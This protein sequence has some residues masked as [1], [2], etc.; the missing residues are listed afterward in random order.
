MTLE[1]LTQRWV[2]YG[3]A[4]SD[5]ELL[6]LVEAERGMPAAEDDALMVD[7][8]L[9]SIRQ[10]VT[11]DYPTELATDP[12][13]PPS[14]IEAVVIDVPVDPRLGREHDRVRAVYRQCRRSRDRRPTVLRVRAVR[15]VARRRGAGAP[16]RRRTAASTSSG[17]SDPGDESAPGEPAHDEVEVAALLDEAVGPLAVRIAHALSSW[18]DR[19]E[20]VV[21]A[22]VEAWHLVDVALP[23]A[24][25]ILR[26]AGLHAEGDRELFG[27]GW[28]V[29][30]TGV[31][32]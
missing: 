26:R 31:K 25:V 23:L 22:D 20:V 2:L 27:D 29:V 12:P 17:S 19:G 3:V 32:S 7:Y 11:N 28:A 14:P 16:S 1:E 13:L 15:P 10:R 6:P 4:P 30:V 5:D 8:M 21:E 24:L 9:Q 18:A